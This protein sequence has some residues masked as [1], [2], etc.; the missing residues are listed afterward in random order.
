MTRSPALRLV[1]PAVA[2]TA[3]LVLAACVSYAPK[4][5][6]GS[7]SDAEA[8]LASPDR[9]TLVRRAAQFQHPRLPPVALDFSQPLDADEIAVLAVIGN[10][11]L[12][13]LREQQRV[14]DAQVFAAGLLPDPQLSLGLDQV[15]SPRGQGLT[16]AFAG[17]LTLDLLGAL[18]TRHVER[19][20]AQSAATQVRLDIAWQEWTIAGQARLQAIRLPRQRLAARIAREAATAAEAGLQ[21]TLT[22]AV[23]GDLK[24]DEVAAQRI[25][26]ADASARALTAERDADTARL[27]LNRLLGLTPSEPLLIADAP[28]L[29]AWTAPD[30]EALFTAA[31][32]AR[33]DLQA[34]AAGYDSQEAILHRAVLG[35]YPRLAITLNRGRDTGNVQTFGP[36]VSLDL[37]LWNRNRGAIAVADVDRDRLRSEYAARLHQTRADIAALVAALSRDEQSRAGLAAQLPGIEQVAGRFEAAALRGDVIVTLAES[38]RASAVDKRLALL[39]LERAIAEQRLALALAVGR[40]LSEPSPTP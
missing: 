33:L 9:A 13:G 37:P 19:Q 34:L 36:A 31:R 10:P 27:E 22:A 20:T 1:R 15:L 11:D 30:P 2:I 38:A 17:A 40:P 28:T 29:S 6:N 21:R 12:R 23:R 18:V 3:G 26:A 4:P 5:L 14:A 25:A 16:T 7:G 35:Q 39:A 32:E 24:G 8:V